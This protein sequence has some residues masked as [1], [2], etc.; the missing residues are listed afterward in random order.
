MVDGLASAEA[1][2]RNLPHET[3]VIHG[4]ED[5]VIRYRRHCNWPADSNA[6]LHVFGHRPWTQIEHAGRF[7]RLVEDFLS[8][9][10]RF[11]ST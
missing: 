2:I 10:T 7:A 11:R 4:R 8:E 1:D 9:P 5:Q 3:L 6:Q